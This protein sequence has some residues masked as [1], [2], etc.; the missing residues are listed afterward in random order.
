MGLNRWSTFKQVVNQSE[1]GV[2][3]WTPEFSFIQ[4]LTTS[5]NIIYR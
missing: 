1:H 5:V 3:F 4:F 2:G